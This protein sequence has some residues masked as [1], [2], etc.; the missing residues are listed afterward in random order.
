MAKWLLQREG[1]FIGDWKEVSRHDDE[2]AAI[3]A[4]YDE[5]DS[6]KEEDYCIREEGQRGMIY[7]AHRLVKTP[8]PRCGKDARVREML[9]TYDCHGI[10]F[11]MVCEDCFV[12]IDA[13][14]GYDGEYYDERDECIDYDY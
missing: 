9:W 1:R 7:R 5:F 12:E 3:K 2:F 6:G 10:P 14:P 11:R 13:G 4:M 8:C